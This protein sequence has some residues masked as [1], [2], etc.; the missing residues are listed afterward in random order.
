[1]LSFLCGILPESAFYNRCINSLSLYRNLMT[2][3]SQL[4]RTVHLLYSHRVI[5]QGLIDAAR[6]DLVWGQGRLRENKYV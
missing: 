2:R 3:R 4:E 5:V 6:D 1:M